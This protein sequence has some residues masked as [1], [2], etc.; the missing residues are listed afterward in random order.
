MDSGRGACRAL[1]LELSIEDRVGQRR[2]ERRNAR[3]SH[4]C[5]MR[6]QI[7]R[8]DRGAHDFQEVVAARMGRT[9]SHSHCMRACGMTDVSFRSLNH[10]PTIV[11]NARPDVWRQV[12]SSHPICFAKREKRPFP[13]RPKHTLATSPSQ[14][15]GDPRR[16][17][18][19]ESAQFLRYQAARRIHKA[20]RPCPGFEWNEYHDQAAIVYRFRDLIR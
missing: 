11:S 19:Q 6:R 18:T 1:V 4:T 14:F 2:D 13:N 12:Y 3:I 15:V 20:H 5:G 7:V 16:S 10:N 8:H 9:V 17:E